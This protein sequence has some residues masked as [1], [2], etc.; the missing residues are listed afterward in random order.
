MERQTKRK[1]NQQASWEREYLEWYQRKVKAEGECFDG[2]AMAE[3][4]LAQW[5]RKRLVAEAFRRCTRAWRVDEYLMSLISPEERD[6]R[7]RVVG[8]LLLEHPAHG[9][10]LV[11]L[12]EEQTTQGG[13]AIGGF[14][15]LDRVVG[16]R[17]SAQEW[18]DVFSTSGQ[19]DLLTPVPERPVPALGV[20]HV[21]R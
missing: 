12:I 7:G 19:P 10:L 3:L 1:R 11:D 6:M 20:I 14:E 9:T 21:K 13:V 18:L 16:Y 2:P 4:A 5:P 17:R 15:Y 8:S